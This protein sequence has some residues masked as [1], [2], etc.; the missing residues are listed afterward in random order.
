MKTTLQDNAKVR[1][2]MVDF[3]LARGIGW[4]LLGGLAGTVT[5]DIVLI[6][7]S[8]MLGLNGIQSFSV[9]GDTAARFFTLLGL[10]LTGGVPTGL[11]VHY[12][13]GPMLGAIFGAAVTRFNALWPGTLLKGIGLGVLY[14]EV[15]SQ[16]LLATTPILLNMSAQDT[17]F[18]YAL[19]TGMHVLY[20]AAL[21]AVVSYGLRRTASQPAAR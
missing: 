5:M 14:V 12:L 9:I 16:P 20:G 21:G 6:V 11:T 13:A 15:A 2:P 3:A 7:A 4:G 19:S 1:Q 10:G 18:W 8:P 17:A